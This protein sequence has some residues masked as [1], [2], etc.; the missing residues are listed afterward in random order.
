VVSL[1][2]TQVS[3]LGVSPM[4]G[5]CMWEGESESDGGVGMI[6]MGGSCVWAEM[7]ESNATFS[8]A[9]RVFSTSLVCGNCPPD[10]PAALRSSG[11]PFNRG[12]SCGEGSSRVGMYMG[13]DVRVGGSE[14]ERK[15]LGGVEGFNKCE[16]SSA[17]SSGSLGDGVGGGEGLV[18][19]E[20][21]RWARIDRCSKSRLLSGDRGTPGVLVSGNRKV[22]LRSGD[23]KSPKKTASPSPI[24]SEE[25]KD[26]DGWLS[27]INKNINSRNLR[28]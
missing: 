10:C 17:T 28:A 2:T 6:G 23:V 26:R 15:A 20:M 22:N 1:E 19:E 3:A 12:V 5:I 4:G 11:A 21:T 7:F 8:R 24:V 13:V 16:I 27:M 25:E 14:A 9:K 18:C